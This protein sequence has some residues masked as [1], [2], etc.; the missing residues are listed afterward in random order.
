MWKPFHLPMTTHAPTLTPSVPQDQS[1]SSPR[2]WRQRER[3]QTK[4]LMSRTMVLHVRFESLY[5]LS[6]SSVQQQRVERNLENV[7]PNG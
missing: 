1:F 3:H 6:P 5:I 4:G 7:N 2:R